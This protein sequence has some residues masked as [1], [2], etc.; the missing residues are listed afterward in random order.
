[1]HEF[2]KPSVVELSVLGGVP[3]CFWSNEIKAGSMQVAVSTIFKLP[4][5]LASVAEYTTL[6]IVLH[7]V[8]IGP[9]ILGVGFIRLGEGQ[10][11][12]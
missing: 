8:W 9:F 2:L 1:M 6:G 10:S 3:G 5:V 7:T 4:H 11:L 12:S